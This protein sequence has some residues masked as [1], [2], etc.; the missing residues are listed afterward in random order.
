MVLGISRDSVEENRAFAEKF[1]FPFPLLCDVDGE[2]SLAYGAIGDAS[3]M[4]P[5]RITYV[6]GPD[7]TIVQAHDTVDPKTHPQTLLASL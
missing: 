7:G 4:Y 2:V 3:E 6:V 5:N 1:G